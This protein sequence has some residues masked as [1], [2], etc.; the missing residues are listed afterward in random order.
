MNRE[1]ERRGGGRQL[2]WVGRLLRYVVLG[3]PTVADWWDL[4]IRGKGLSGLSRDQC[5]DWIGEQMSVISPCFSPYT[6]HKHYP[7][8]PLMIS[9]IIPFSFAAWA[10]LASAASQIHS[11]KTQLMWKIK[12]VYPAVFP[13][14]LFHAPCVSKMFFIILVQTISHPFVFNLPYLSF[15]GD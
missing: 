10:T 15:V 1:D 9:P 13:I 5:E 14:F 7:L 3:W 4:G 12:G 6:R 8:R 2:Q 11:Q